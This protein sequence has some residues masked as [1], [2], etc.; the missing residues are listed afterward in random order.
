MV[1]AWR[2]LMWWRCGNRGSV[3]ESCGCVWVMVVLF[4]RHDSCHDSG[5]GGLCSWLG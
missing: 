3:L 4:V 5:F 2:S 1:E